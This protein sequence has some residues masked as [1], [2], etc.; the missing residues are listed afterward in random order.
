MGEDA[1]ELWKENKP[2]AVTRTLIM[3]PRHLG[4]PGPKLFLEK[5]G[6]RLEGLPGFPQL[7]FGQR[8]FHRGVEPRDGSGEILFRE[9]LDKL[10]ARAGDLAR[11]RP[12]RQRRLD[13]NNHPD[14]RQPPKR[15]SIGH[16]VKHHAAMVSAGLPLVHKVFDA[17]A[18]E[19]WLC[20]PNGGISVLGPTAMQ[21]SRLC[22]AFPKQVQLR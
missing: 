16:L 14:H 13:G 11:R 21:C 7:R 18:N 12:P 3:A 4:R 10:L 19:V 17:G 6:L 15:R 9:Q 20:A 2:F 22:S 1:N 5:T 8:S